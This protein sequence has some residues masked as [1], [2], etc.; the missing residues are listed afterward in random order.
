MTPTSPPAVPDAA[1]VSQSR[2]VLA[3]AVCA[4]GFSAFITQLTLLRELLSVFS[5][6]ELVLGIALGSWLLLTGSGAYLGR[7]A[8]RL[9]HPTTVLAVAQSAIAVLPIAL[10]FLL[11][12][13]R[14]VVFHRGAAVGLT[15]T[16]VVCFAL[17]LPYC[18]LAG[19]LLT[20]A[21]SLLAARQDASSLG[22]VYGL[23][24]V[25][26]VAGGVMFTWVFAERLNHFQ[27][28]YVPAALNL[29]LAAVVAV[30]RRRRGVLAGTL[31][32]AAGL[33][34]VAAG[35]DLN[36]RSA[37]ALFPGQNLIHL[38]HSPYGSVAVT[39]SSG[40]LN[41]YESGVPLFSTGIVE[42]VE[43]TVHLAMAQRDAPRRVLLVSGGITGTAREIMRYAEAEV[44][45][46]EL[47][48]LVL[49]VAQRYWPDS[50]LADPRIHVIHAD[51][52]SWVRTAETRYDVVIVDI[53]DPSNAQLNRFYTREFF[54]EVKR[55]LAP[56]GVLS[57]GLRHYENYLSPELARLIA[58][59]HETL[60]QEFGH[61]LMLPAGRV[62]FLASDGPLT[63]DVVPRWEQRGLRH[64]WLTRENTADLFR[65]ERLAAVQRAVAPGAPVNTDFHPVLCYYDLA[66]WLSQ[67]QVR[68]GVWGGGL[69]LLFLVLLPR[70]RSVSSVVF[71]LGLA[72]SALE[73][74]LLYGHQ[75]LYGSLYHEVSRIVTLFMVGVG[76][77]S[78][79]ANRLAASRARRVLVWI[80]LATVAYAVCLPAALMALGRAETGT[81]A[82]IFGRAAIPLLT[83]VLGLL[84]GAAFPLAGKADF[85]TV[86]RTAARVYAADYLGAAVGALLISTWLIPLAGIWAVCLL[87]AALNLAGGAVLW[88][89]RGAQ[90]VQ[91]VRQAAGS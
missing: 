67:F 31:V 56:E 5:G 87:C 8:D 43:E 6:N 26:G 28:L 91:A 76:I 36:Y 18:I 15:E 85:H 45:Y 53:P 75:I 24:T 51:G 60:A 66:Y 44:D 4:L 49:T 90:S 65:A 63:A 89:T 62:Y 25:G 72:G 19:Y 13:L 46:V 2:R 12:T 47:D 88:F 71:A 7:A 39:E 42:K 82:A 78:L 57:L 69:L 58:V 16:V 1:A 29:L 79:A 14:Y 27:I 21:T 20:L 80:E 83:L 35:Y 34:G 38:G 33:G 30:H 52:R 48:P 84:V 50:G 74:V 81:V 77:G 70:A 9:R 23:D 68:C 10:V 61:V 32:L 37:Q 41:F 22:F 86:A 73:V 3:A 54:R 17:L 11:R 40:Q 64:L 55:C 59:T